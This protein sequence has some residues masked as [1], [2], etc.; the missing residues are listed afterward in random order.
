M[1]EDARRSSSPLAVGDGTGGSAGGPASTESGEWR[2]ESAAAGSDLDRQIERLLPALRPAVRR[3]VEYHE[4]RG[5][6]RP[7]EV[8]PDDL[9]IEAVARALREREKAPPSDKLY[10]WLLRFAYYV[11]EKELD[12]YQETIR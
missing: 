1:A 6:L 3:H 8:E 2:V 11:V 12:P 7:R 4:A 9:M 5:D 10:R